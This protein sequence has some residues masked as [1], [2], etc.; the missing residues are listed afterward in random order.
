MR[1]HHSRQHGERLPNRVCDV[2]DD[3]FYCKHEKR[4]CSPKC[5][6][7][8]RSLS[9]SSN[10]NFRGGKETASCEICSTQFEYYPSEKEGI[11]C[12]ECVNSKTWQEPPV[13]RGEEHPRWKGGK[14]GG[15]CTV[16]GET[17][18]R[19]PS[20]MTGEVTVCS[21][22]CRRRWLSEEFSGEGHPN[23]KGGGNEA[24]GKGWHA[25][26]QRA[27]ERDDYTCVLCSKTKAEIGRNPDVHHIVPV[28]VFIESDEYAREDAHVLT[29]VI[30]LCIDCHRKADF[31]KFSKRDLWAR[32]TKNS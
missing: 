3:Q 28:R 30:T 5:R 26:R 17:V 15:E 19:Y 32:I 31:G 21:E 9:G 10:P 13:V 14:R 4:Y 18:V 11:Y 2:C 6:Q 25:V 22:A 12:P 1:V 8:G 7:E 20:N 23:W 29:N 24:Y 16:C 27:L